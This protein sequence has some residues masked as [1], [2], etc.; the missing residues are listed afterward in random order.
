MPVVSPFRLE[1]TRMV[2][3]HLIVVM[4]LVPILAGA[5]AG[6]GAESDP[7]PGAERVQVSP[8]EVR[9]P[10]PSGAEREIDLGALVLR[11]AEATGRTVARPS[12]PVPLPLNG[13][14]GGLTRRLLADSLG[15]EVAIDYPADA[16]EAGTLIVRL[17]PKLRE[18]GRT[19]WQKRLDALAARAVREARRRLEY[20]MHALRSYRPNDPARPTVCMVHGLNSSSGG[21]V[22]MIRPLEEAGYGVVVFDYPFNRPLDES[23]ARFARDWKAFRTRPG[24]DPSLGDPGPLDGCP[25]GPFVCRGSPRLR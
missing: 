13:P 7:R 14:A 19:D 11:L 5:G 1:R 16:G 24:R 4:G 3:N 22:H 15:P 8:V 17:D 18:P 2:A 9:L 6:A 10:V 12:G 23:S 25:V 21:F 20:G